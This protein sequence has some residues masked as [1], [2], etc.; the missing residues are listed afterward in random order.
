MSLGKE[1]PFKELLS[2]LRDPQRP[3]IDFKNMDTIFTFKALQPRKSF[4]SSA[5]S[6]SARCDL[7]SSESHRYHTWAIWVSCASDSLKNVVHDHPIVAIQASPVSTGPLPLALWIT[8]FR[9]MAAQTPSVTSAQLSQSLPNASTAA[10]SLWVQY[11]RCSHAHR[12][13]R[14]D[15]NHRDL[16]KMR[17]VCSLTLGLYC[18]CVGTGKPDRIGSSVSKLCLSLS[19][20]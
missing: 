1:L 15:D 4:L 18:G 16:P 14:S 20:E 9:P 8:A 3:L 17:D 13:C 6:C 10:K 11:H 7:A 5:F 19:L 2:A 12:T